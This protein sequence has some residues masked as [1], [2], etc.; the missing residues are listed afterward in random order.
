MIPPNFKSKEFSNKCFFPKTL[1][2]VD[3]DK[4]KNNQVIERNIHCCVEVLQ[5][6]PPS[7]F[8]PSTNKIMVGGPKTLDGPKVNHGQLDCFQQ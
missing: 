5:R 8:F 4:L 6:V 3:L 7:N 2:S 1:Q